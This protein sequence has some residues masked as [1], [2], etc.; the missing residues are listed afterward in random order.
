MLTAMIPNVIG[1]TAHVPCFSQTVGGAFYF[2]DKY[3]ATAAT[4]TGWQEHGY[5]VLDAS[6][7]SVVYKTDC[8]TVQ[9]PA[10]NLIPQIKI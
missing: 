8:N 4:G 5:T 10:I 7:C 6:R 1:S 2:V 9:P 3:A